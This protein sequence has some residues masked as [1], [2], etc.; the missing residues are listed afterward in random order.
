VQANQLVDALLKENPKDTDAIAMHAA[1]ML[2][3]GNRD[4]VT[5][6]ATELQSLV[7]KNPTNHLLLFNYARAL[8]AQAQLATAPNDRNAKVEQARLQLEDAKKVRPDFIAAREMLARVYLAKQDIPKAL[9]AA[10]DV[11]QLDKNN[12]AGHLIRSSSL[13]ALGNMD[14]AREELDLITQLFPQNPDARYQVGLLAYQDKDYK[15]ADQVFQALYRDNPRDSRG[16]NGITE[17]LAAQNRLDDAIKAMDKALAAE[18]DR[19]EFKLARANFYARA[20][21]YDEAIGTYK[22][23]LEKDPSAKADLFFKLGETYRL[24]GDINLAADAFRKSS[25][26]APNSTTPL[27]YLGMILETLGPADQAKAVYEQILKLDPN[28]ALALNNLAMRKADEG[29][30][31]DS[32]LTMAQKARQIQ[33]N[34]TAMAD[35]VG[36]IYIKKNLSSEAERIFKDLVAKEPANATYH[37]HYG[38]ALIQKGDKSSARREF[39]AALKNKPSKDEAGKIQNELTKL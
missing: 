36:W 35:T 23:L 3:S 11:L 1:L 39:E 20:Q 33:P 15:K 24:K 6:A 31:L 9:Q 28:N 34:A 32:A 8:L 10:E 19:T 25:Q 17:T 12:L 29:Q 26:A 4:Q 37:Y 22:E 7:R 38:L 13:L 5:Q 27:V 16:L 2:N 21:R 18:P 30:D 14:K